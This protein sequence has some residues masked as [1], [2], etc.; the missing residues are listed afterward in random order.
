MS[1]PTIN[2]L[3]TTLRVYLEGKYPELTSDELDTVARIALDNL[4]NNTEFQDTLVDIVRNTLDEYV[5]NREEVSETTRMLDEFDEL[6]EKAD[7]L[8]FKLQPKYPKVIV[9]DCICGAPRTRIYCTFDATH[10]GRVM[11]CHNCLLEGPPAKYQYQAKE[12][13][14]KMIVEKLIEKQKGDGD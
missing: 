9:R 4:R 1:K 2:I 3:N 6:K 13:W 7:K 14:N 8:G 11:R 5:N 12:L 10:K